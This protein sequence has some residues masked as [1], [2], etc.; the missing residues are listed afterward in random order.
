M[1]SFEFLETDLIRVGISIVIGVIIGF[2]REYHNKSAGLR[3][4]TLVSFGAC[5]FTILS[6]RM[7]MGSETDR[8]AANI[9]TG[10]GF[11]GAGVIFKSENRLSGITT[12]TTI[13]AAASLGMAA[14][15]GH[16]V[17]AFTGVA[18]VIVV[19]SLLIPLQK[20]IDARN[21]VRLY[22]ITTPNVKEID[23]GIELMKKFELNAVIVGQI[24]DGN[25]VETTWELSGKRNHHDEFVVALLKDSVINHFQY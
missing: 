4:F 23:Y 6:E 9:V 11:L 15:S 19:L 16:Y 22:K 12:A 13:W 25:S 21:F 10:I 24:M 7:G 3:T 8:I 20:I 14:G 2:E 18:I 5:I 17:L 1:D